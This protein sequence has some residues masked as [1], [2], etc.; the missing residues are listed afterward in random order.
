MV[1]A[2]LVLLAIPFINTSDI[3]N[4]TYRPFFKF[5][6]WF[7]LADFILLIWVGQKPVRDNFILL[8]QVATLYYFLFFLILIPLIGVVESKLAH[9]KFSS[10]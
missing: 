2:I 5:F 8:G 10:Y 1:G 9:Y 3:R 4:T 7:F 6:F